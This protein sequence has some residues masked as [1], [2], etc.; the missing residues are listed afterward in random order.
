MPISPNDERYVFMPEADIL[1]VKGSAYALV[2]RDHFWSV[3]PEKGLR[4]WQSVPGRKG[5]LLGAGPQC[6]S[7]ESIARRL[8]VEGDEVKQIPLVLA[9]ISVSDYGN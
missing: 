5:K 6:N 9:P 3:H 2:I 8:L 4:F 1:A 7:N